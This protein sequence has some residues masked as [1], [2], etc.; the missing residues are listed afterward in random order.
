[1][2]NRGQV[3]IFVILGL[4]IITVVLLIIFLSSSAVRKEEPL[5][6]SIIEGEISDIKE[7]VTS[8]LDDSLKQA[9]EYCSGNLADGGPKC[10]DYEGDIAARVEEGF[11]DCVPNCNDFSNFKN[12]QIEVKGEM[13]LK[14]KLSGDKKKITLTMGYPILVTKGGSEHMLG[15]QESPFITEYALEQSECVPVKIVDRTSCMAAETKTVEI[16]GL[17]LTYRENVDKVAI[18]GTCIAC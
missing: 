18:G 14:A 3:T 5:K 13:N 10:T 15:T 9:V 11:C 12:I 1:M 16:L 2:K 17:I 7:Y 6:E 4:V 8:C